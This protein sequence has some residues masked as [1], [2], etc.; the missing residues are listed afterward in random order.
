MVRGNGSDKQPTPSINQPK[1]R[2][3]DMIVIECL[4]PRQAR[5]G[6]SHKGVQSYVSTPHRSLCPFASEF[7]IPSPAEARAGGG[8]TRGSARA[9]AEEARGGDEFRLRRGDEFSASCLQNK[10]RRRQRYLRF[11][12]HE[13]GQRRKVLGDRA[14]RAGKG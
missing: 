5:T 1:T 7:R 3:Q 11:A 8:H 4:I 10:P 6:S 9:G 12:R 14:G 2:R 13:A